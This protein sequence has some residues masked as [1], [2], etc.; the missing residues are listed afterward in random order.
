ME[1][2]SASLA[3]CVG[4]SPVPGEFPSQ[5]PATRSFDVFFDMRLNNKRLSKQS[6]GWWF[7]TLS[8]PLWRHSNGSFWSSKCMQTRVFVRIGRDLRSWI[9][10]WPVDLQYVGH[11]FLDCYKCIFIALDNHSPLG[12]MAVG[13]LV[14]V[15]HQSSGKHQYGTDWTTRTWKVT[16]FKFVGI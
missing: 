14:Y 6:W 10:L 16:M 5:R 15:W 2:F 11:I 9:S 7:E 1:T 8:S 4:N 13:V 12:M 3:I